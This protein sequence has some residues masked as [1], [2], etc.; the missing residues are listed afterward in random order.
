M[1]YVS[2]E[3]QFYIWN[4]L[5]DRNFMLQPINSKQDING[6]ENN[7]QNKK[8]IKHISYRRLPERRQNNN[9]QYTFIIH[10]HTITIRWTNTEHIL[11]FRKIRISHTT[12]L[13]GKSPL[14]LKSVENIS[15]LYILRI[16]IIECSEVNGENILFVWEH[17]WVGIVN[18]HLQQGVISGRNILI[19]HHQFGEYDRWD[20]ATLTNRVGIKY[21][22]SPTGT[23]KHTSFSR[24]CGSRFTKAHWESNTTFVV[25]FKTFF[26]RDKFTNSILRTN[27]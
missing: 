14:F 22:D 5:F 25:T 27:P 1:R 19:S 6:Y 12:L 11:S 8:N 15:I 9:V 13:V 20:I 24:Q 17:Q 3:T 4:L 21:K 7:N 10:P 2:K 18:I 16:S 23:E 26:R